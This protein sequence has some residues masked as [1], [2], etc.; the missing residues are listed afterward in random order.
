LVEILPDKLKN[1]LPTVDE[2]ERDLQTLTIS[3]NY[4]QSEE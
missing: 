1:A 4:T 3:E 2:I